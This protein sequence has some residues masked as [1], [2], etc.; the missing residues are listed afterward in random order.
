VYRYTELET[1]SWRRAGMSGL[2]SPQLRTRSFPFHALSAIRSS[3]AVDT[4]LPML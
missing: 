2:D 4:K 3:P 1:I